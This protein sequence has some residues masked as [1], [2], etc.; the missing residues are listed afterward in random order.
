MAID[1]EHF[2]RSLDALADAR[3]VMNKA[4]AYI[5]A[6][7][8]L[9]G[10]AR[11]A[12]AEYLLQHTGKAM[13]PDRVWWNV[14]DSAASAPTF[15]GWRHTGPPRQSM[16]F[17]QLLIHRFDDG[18]QLAP[19][20]LPLYGGFYTR[21]S[22]ASDYGV[23]NEVRLL[24]GKVMA[25]LWALDFTSLIGQRTERFWREQG[26]DFPLLAKVRF[27]AQIEE[28]LRQRALTEIDRQRL[29]AW[30]GLAEGKVTLASLQGNTHSDAF[31]IRH[32]L[33]PGGGHLLTL[34]ATDGRTVLY[35][36]GTEWLPRAFANQGDLVHWV[37]LQLRSPDTFNAL[38]RVSEQATAAE[39]G[40]AMKDLLKRIGPVQ[41]PTWPFGAGREVTDE[42]FVELREWAKA[43]L[44]VTHSAAVSNGQLRR[45]LWRGYLG[46]FLRVF[47]GL[48]AMAWPLG[49]VMLGAAVAR[50]SL[51]IDAAVRA[52]SAY[53][54]T[55]AIID[56]VADTVAAVFSIIDVGLGVKALRF[57]APP[58]ERLMATQALQPSDQ[59]GEELES[60]D[61]NRILPE[62]SSAPGTLNG[63]SV[64]T[65]GSTWIEMQ[66]LTLRVRHS[67]EAGGWL[68]VDDD[69]PFAFLPTPRLQIADPS[70][71][72]V[73]EVAQ[74]TA[75]ASGTLESVASGF[76]DTYMQANFEPHWEMSQELLERQ[77]E[78]LASAMLPSPS[79]SNPL[80][81]N[82]R[83][84][85][86]LL[87]DGKPWFTWI[88][89]DY[90]HNDLVATYTDEMFQANAL[91]RHGGDVDSEVVAYLNDLFDSLAPL[92]RS[93]S[94]R[95]WRGGSDGRA[96]GGGAFRTGALN[97]GDVLVT[98]DITSFTENPYTLRNFVAPRQ[99][100]GLDH[101]NVFDDSSVIYELVD[102][103]L[104]SGVPIGPMSLVST[105]A[106]V[107][108]TPG[109]FFHVESVR[110]VRGAHYYFVR[111]RLREVEKPQG[112]T[113]YDLRTGEPFDRAAYATK[114][115]HESLVE[116]F[117]PAAQWQ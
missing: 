10:L 89:D 91:F 3:A 50:V 113:V 14:F 22:G 39:H 9:Y 105:E 16:T 11:K 78:T 102:R 28:G 117:F 61:G 56:A 51:D 37:S 25:D 38:Y 63:V 85:R 42:L 41:A 58:H 84:F 13:D 70:S 107:I 48:A 92:P 24:P 106:E 110:E 60:L 18:F 44:A 88:E 57:Q 103:G 80:L 7:P 114:V 65:D 30:L 55:Q 20:T 69:D 108:F 93:E 98:T 109:R 90:F 62:P 5:Q 59:V 27:I 76:W 32:Y 26:A 31:H 82:A 1:L 68:A 67:P 81:E 94:L 64:D 104:T 35:C 75:A 87:K 45:T 96:T 36:P 4:R 73:L 95:L 53:E 19:D 15:T 116:R 112:G 115:G 71:W 54:R 101:V 100:R 43:D 72:Q 23:G 111:V 97:S 99:M 8:D 49:L 40:H 2:E 79:A 33:I 29:R 52:H 21:G 47:G 74:P 77:R 86:Y 12:A 6:W 34:R 17:T 66:D 46:A 83:K